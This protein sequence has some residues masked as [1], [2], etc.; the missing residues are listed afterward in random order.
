M[1]MTR[2]RREDLHTVIRFA[3]T[4]NLQDPDMRKRLRRAV[5][6]LAVFYQLYCSHILTP[7]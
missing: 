2:E 5:N 1:P 4:Q 6:K 7:F 3:H